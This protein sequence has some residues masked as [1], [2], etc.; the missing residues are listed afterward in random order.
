[1]NTN[2]F[3]QNCLTRYV[4]NVL[5]GETG[6]DRQNIFG[7]TDVFIN[8]KYFCER[9]YLTFQTIDKDK[10]YFYKKNTGLSFNMCP[11]SP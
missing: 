8:D 10:S 5:R 1:M 3:N 2:F 6:P 9:Q 4:S 11:V 7:L